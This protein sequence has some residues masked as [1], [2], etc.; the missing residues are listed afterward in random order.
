MNKK[1]KMNEMKMDWLFLKSGRR[2]FVCRKKVLMFFVIEKQNTHLCKSISV[3]KQ[4][5]VVLYYLMDERQYRKFGNAFGI[6]R[7]SVLLFVRSVCKAIAA[8]FG[9]KFVKFPS[10]E[11]EVSYAVDQFEKLLGFPHCLGA[12]DGIYIFI[13]KT[14]ESPTDY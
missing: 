3:E 2:I 5:A 8:Q 4:V 12:V 1:L 13:K 6:S 7:S 10:T 9:H 14:A 11:E